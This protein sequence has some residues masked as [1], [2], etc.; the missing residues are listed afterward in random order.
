MVV[1][2]ILLAVA[3]GS[4]VFHWLSPWWWT[5]IASNWHYID[6]TLIITF[7]ITGIAFVAVVGFL[8][9]CVFRYRHRAAPARVQPLGGGRARVAFD[10][11]QRA[12]TPG[13]A[14]VLY[15][16]DQVLGG[17]WIEAAT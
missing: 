8:A 3:L 17:G 4:V 9:S 14:V 16:G 7:W 13:Q 15:R 10:A 5:P 11:P 2:F 6:Q 12:V 1:A